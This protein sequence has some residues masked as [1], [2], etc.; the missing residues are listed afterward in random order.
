[1]V[2]LCIPWVFRYILPC[3]SSIN[4]LDEG[5]GICNALMNHKAVWHKDCVRPFHKDKLEKL[6]D[7]LAADE[8]ARSKTG[9]V[10]DSK[11]CQAQG[12]RRSTRSSSSSVD[13]KDDVCFLCSDPGSRSNPLHRCETKEI[14]EH[15]KRCAEAIGEWRTLGLLSDGDLIAQEGKYHA[16]CLVSLYNR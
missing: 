13:M 2:V 16:K 7:A 9:L 12:D 14:Y 1:M 5:E 10:S 4:N 15:I 3:G 11:A 8:K 6:K